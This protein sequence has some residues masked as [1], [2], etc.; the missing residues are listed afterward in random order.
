MH[1]LIHLVHQALFY[2]S[3]SGIVTYIVQLVRVLFQIVELTAFALVE[4]ELIIGFTD[5]ALAAYVEMAVELSEN[6]RSA[7]SGRASQRPR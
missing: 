5:E 6:V 2:V 3:I 4:R 1:I 7:V